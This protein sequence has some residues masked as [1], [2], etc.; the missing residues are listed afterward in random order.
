MDAKTLS[1][2]AG[3]SDVAFTLNVYVSPSNEVAAATVNQ[4][5][6]AIYQTK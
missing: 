6:K 2:F 5:D 3:H 4:V 1:R